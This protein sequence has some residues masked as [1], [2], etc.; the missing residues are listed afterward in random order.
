M[1][2][3]ICVTLFIALLGSVINANKNSRN[4]RLYLWVSFG[5][6]ICL[7]GLRA[8]SIGIDLQGH[9]AIRYTQIASYEWSQIPQFAAFSHYEIGYCYFCKLLSSINSSI[10]F[11]IITTST[12]TYGIIAL[13]IYKKS[14]DV[15]MSTLLFVF[16]CQYYMY[17]NIIRQSLAI[18][19]ILIGFLYLDGAKR[20]FKT[21]AIVSALILLATTF[22]SSAILCFMIL[23]FDFLKFKKRTIILSL[24]AV[25]GSFLLYEYLYTSVAT[26]FYNDS[27]RY[28][29]YLD[30]I[31][32][33]VGHVNLQSVANAVLTSGAFM[34]GAYYMIYKRRI[35]ISNTARNKEKTEEYIMARHENLLMY[36]CLV[37]SACR[38]LIFRINIV[39][40]FSYYF[41][42]FI[43]LLYP[44]AI[45][46]IK[47]KKGRSITKTWVY[48]SFAIYFVWMTYAYAEQFYGTVPF[49]FFWQ[50]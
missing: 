48:G 31:R 40:R 27:G 13:L 42:P 37:A 29:G 45:S 5:M 23:F 44:Y 32:E 7:A 18:A 33:G 12:I 35:N 22:H 49:A 24:I 26:L 41:L 25:I 28:L 10:Q 15:K 16:T 1:M 11:Y 9:Y 17:M 47:S 36:L 14:K 34:L 19:I 21:Y 46:T 4:K 8:S 6:L 20:T 30:N 3:Y 50:M 2:I 38:I 39:N 43:I